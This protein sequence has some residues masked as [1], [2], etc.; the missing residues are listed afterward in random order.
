LTTFTSAGGGENGGGKA[1]MVCLDKITCVKMHDL[2]VAKWQEKAA[3]LE[4][5][6]A[7]EEALFAAKGKAPAEAAASSAGSTW[8]G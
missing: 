3:Q 8:S 7:A 5:S 4:T 6:V 1:L 2:I